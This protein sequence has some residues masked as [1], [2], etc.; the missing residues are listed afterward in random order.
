MADTDGDYQA[1]KLWLHEM[2]TSAPKRVRDNWMR[3][4]TDGPE[5]ECFFGPSD[6]GYS[7]VVAIES[8]PEYI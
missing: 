7:F 1:V 4:G 3:E 5:R 2:T 8:P 6:S